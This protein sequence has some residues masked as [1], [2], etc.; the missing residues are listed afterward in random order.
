MWKG[1]RGKRGGGC[2]EEW[3]ETWE[4]KRGGRKRNEMNKKKGRKGW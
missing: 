1:R 4:E 2:R 3:G